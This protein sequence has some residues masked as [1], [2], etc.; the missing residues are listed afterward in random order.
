MALDVA[1]YL[2]SLAILKR[3]GLENKRYRT[4]DGRYILDNKDL[5][6]VRFTSEE[7]VKGLP[8]EMISKEEVKKL[9]AQ[10]G[11]N[12]SVPAEFIA[13]QTSANTTEEVT[14][15]AVETTEVTTETTEEVTTESEE[16]EI[17]EETSEESVSEESGVNEATEEETVAESENE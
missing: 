7:I 5:L 10:G 6:R 15:E 12:R 4:A 2:A 16:A 1:Y 9:I 11:Y 14:E 3:A 17:A 8:V 13:A